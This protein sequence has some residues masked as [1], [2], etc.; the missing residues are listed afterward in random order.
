MTPVRTDRAKPSALLL[1]RVGGPFDAAVNVRAASVSGVTLKTGC[2][3][4]AIGP[5]QGFYP[6]ETIWA[7][8]R[9]APQQAEFCDRSEFLN[10]SFA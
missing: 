4:L 6:R 10:V 1:L 3:Q 9:L 2:R 7:I 5:A 8:R